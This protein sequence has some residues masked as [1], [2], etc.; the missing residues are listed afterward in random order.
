MEHRRTCSGLGALRAFV[1]E[2]LILEMGELP[3]G[4]RAAWVKIGWEGTDPPLT[5]PLFP[6]C[7][8]RAGPPEPTETP[9]AP[10]LRHGPGFRSVNRGGRV[11]NFTDKQ[12]KAVG[13]LWGAWESGTPDVADEQLL[14]S[15]DSDL[16]RLGDLFR[17]NDAWGTL[18]V[19]GHTR[20][21]HR[22]A[23]EI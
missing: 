17:S 16:T 21:A 3:E 19:E 23:E 12:A 15:A 20:G 22:M 9:A 6:T 1:R 11:F 2:W 5:V 10:A 14:R 7:P 8:A 13:V 4:R 18:I